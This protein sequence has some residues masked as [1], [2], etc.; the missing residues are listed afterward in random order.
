M[1]SD[2]SCVL[3]TDKRFATRSLRL[4]PRKPEAPRPTTWTDDDG[5]NIAAKIARAGKKLTLTFD[6]RAAPAFGD[7][8]ER[9]CRNSTTIHA[10]DAPMNNVARLAASE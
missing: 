8:V 5:K 10:R 1:A 4:A 2:A 6:E 3:D 9:G 7:F